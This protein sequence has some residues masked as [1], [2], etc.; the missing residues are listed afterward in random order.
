MTAVSSLDELE[1]ERLTLRR[2]CEDDAGVFHRMWT[3]RDERV[4]AHRRI[5]ADGHPDVQDIA[6]HIRGQDTSR[7]GLLTVVLRERREVIGYCGIV[8]DG[9][10]PELAFELL[11]AAHNRGYATEAGRAVLDWARAAG[12]SQ[13]GASVWDWNLA[14]R[15]ALEKL[16]F[17]ETGVVTKESVH[18]RSLMT[19]REL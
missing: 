13:L 18:G 17:H 7:P 5:D 14:S 12:Y 4:P 11:R 16:G 2:Q 3:E 9:D 19:V 8:W 1:T 6:A 15:R 10:Q